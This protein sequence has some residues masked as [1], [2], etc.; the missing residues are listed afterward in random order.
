MYKNQLL[1]SFCMYVYKNILT[2]KFLQLSYYNNYNNVLFYFN[3][4]KKSIK[5]ICEYFFNVSYIIIVYNDYVLTKTILF[6]NFM[7]AICVVLYKKYDCQNSD[8]IIIHTLYTFD[9][10]ISKFLY[11]TISY[12]VFFIYNLEFKYT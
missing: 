10:K 12:L 9:I 8:L 3:I 4:F 6:P 2:L 5:I 11:C 7:K 1:S